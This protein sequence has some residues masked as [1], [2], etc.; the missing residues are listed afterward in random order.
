MP[1]LSPSA[2]ETGRRHFEQPAESSAT[3]F[4]STRIERHPIAAFAALTVFYAAAVAALSWTKLLWLDELITL[5]IARLGSVRAIWGALS[6][7]ADPN[8]P[9]MHTLVM[10]STR[11]F[12]EHALAM[13]LPAALG[14]WAGLLALYLFLKP[15]IGVVWSLAGVMLLMG[16][17]AFH[18][19]FESRSYA[20]YFGTTMVAVYCWTRFDDASPSG[21]GRMRA[22]C[23]MGLALALGLCANFFSVLAFVPIAAAEGVRTLLTDEGSLSLEGSRRGFV[24]AVRWPVWIALAIAGTPLLIFRSVAS[25]AIA[26]YAP[27]A[28][29]KVAFAAVPLSYEDMVGR[30]GYFVWGLFAL[31]FLLGLIRALAPQLDRSFSPQWMVALVDAPADA[32]RPLLTLPEAAAVSMLL[33]YPLLGFLMASLHGGML[34]PRF[35]I[36]VC[37]GV[38]I[39]GILCGFRSFGH[40]RSAGL[41]TLLCATCWFAFRWALGAD[42]YEVRKESFERMIAA[43]PAPEYPGQPLVI[44]DDLI[45]LPLEFY[46]PRD[47]AARIVYPIDFPAIMRDRGEASAE[48]NF[49]T[50]RNTVYHFPIETIADLQRSTSTYII[51]TSGIE[52]T[53]EDLG[54]HFYDFEQIPI[55][56][57]SAD[58][59]GAIAPLTHSRPVFFRVAGDRFPQPFSEPIPFDPDDNLPHPEKQKARTP[60]RRP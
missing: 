55:D 3:A 7:G 1:T 52:W 20:L 5:H 24:H 51:L 37:F 42:D 41:A 19:S 34:S 57:H 27:Y 59:E 58:A 17:D 6:T 36:P 44:G 32:V 43:I 48:V 21:A 13:R 33:A 54:R 26:L 22:L 49:W 47:V 28:W 12:G 40:L 35:V 46:A 29:N 14:F 50:G 9:L 38:A 30:V 23:G 11:A 15:R 25:H 8:P 16:M 4:L 39:A 18:W 60:D 2:Q 10:L 56:T 45:V 31:A 53:I